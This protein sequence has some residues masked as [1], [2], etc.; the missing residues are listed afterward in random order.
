MDML[1]FPRAVPHMFYVVFLRAYAGGSR[2]ALAECSANA[3]GLFLVYEVGLSSW[4]EYWVF[5]VLFTDIYKTKVALGFCS[6]FICSSLTW[7]YSRKFIP[8]CTTFLS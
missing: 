7:T 5:F 4:V 2:W 1:T 3:V 8:T 6:Y